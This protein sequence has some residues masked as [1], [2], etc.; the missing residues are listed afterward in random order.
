MEVKACRSENLISKVMRSGAS[1]RWSS[2]GRLGEIVEPPAV[3]GL[4][5][6]EDRLGIVSIRMAMASRVRGGYC[7]MTLLSDHFPPPNLRHPGH[8]YHD[9]GVIGSGLHLIESMFKLTPRQQTCANQPLAGFF[10]RP[11]QKNA[12]SAP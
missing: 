5:G 11:L 2:D 6:L 9:V 12:F 8:E 10:Y 1:D 7:F 3:A 4:G